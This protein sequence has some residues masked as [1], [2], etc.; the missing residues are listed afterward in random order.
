MYLYISL[1]AS[2]CLS[3]TLSVY[4]SIQSYWSV[5]ACWCVL[6][7]SPLSMHLYI[8]STCTLRVEL[9]SSFRMW[10]SSCFHNYQQIFL[11]CIHANNICDIFSTKCRDSRTAILSTCITCTSSY[12]ILPYLRVNFQFFFI[13]PYAPR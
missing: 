9:P 4:E 6:F 12:Y 3:L 1:S 11:P 2:S 10:T 13:F 5:H 8:N 7:I